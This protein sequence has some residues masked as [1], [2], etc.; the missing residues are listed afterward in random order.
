[1]ADTEIEAPAPTHNSST[2]TNGRKGK[3]NVAAKE[4]QHSG[5]DSPQFILLGTDISHLK[6]EHQYAACTVCLFSFSLLYGYLQELISVQIF[7]RDL[8]LFLST[9]QF[10]GY[11]LLVYLLRVY[12]Y[13][14]IHANKKVDSANGSSVEKRD[15]N[16][17]EVPPQLYLSIALLRAL[18]LGL[19]NLGMQYLNYPAKTLLKSSRIVFTM[20]F[21]MF[22]QRKKYQVIDF[23]TVFGMVVGLALFL[24]ADSKSAAVFH[25][26]G[27][28]M[29]LL[30][31][32]C[33]GAI[34]NISE[35]IMTNYGVGQDEVRLLFCAAIVVAEC[36]GC[37]G[38]HRLSHTALT[39]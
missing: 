18:E 7:S 22:I 9:A 11:T 4:D 17:K 12:V 29:L 25:Y 1:M 16:V 24:H 38:C 32:F 39:A 8:A 31:L 28:L 19:T 6:R 36:G 34:V 35:S 13:P 2:A 37:R 23:L 33:D 10:T 15:N 14:T 30:S 3:K 5:D 20:L 27:V 26:M 21:G